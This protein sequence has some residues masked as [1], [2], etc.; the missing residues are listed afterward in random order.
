MNDKG[1]KPFKPMDLVIVDQLTV[2]RAVEQNEPTIVD[3][4]L[5]ARKEISRLRG[6]Q[7]ETTGDINSEY[8][9]VDR[10]VDAIP[11]GAEVEVHAAKDKYFDVYKRSTQEK[12]SRS[13]NVH[14]FHGL[15]YTD[16]FACA[17]LVLVDPNRGDYFV[18]LD[19][20]RAE[21]DYSL[22]YVRLAE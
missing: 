16:G 19:K 13:D 10:L 12:V 11:E 9:S 18:V 22:E 20:H 6:L 14:T 5:T 1:E 2:E 4:I 21:R 7:A 3:G 15:R 17:S 8:H